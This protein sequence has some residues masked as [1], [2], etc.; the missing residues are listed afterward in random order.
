MD[1]NSKK[2]LV[3]AIF[4]LADW[5]EYYSN[6]NTSP[7][8]YLTIV[9]NCEP[10]K[11]QCE[12]LLLEMETQLEKPLQNEEE[13]NKWR[14]VAHEYFEKTIKHYRSSLKLQWSR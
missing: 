12:F 10:H 1:I 13:R 5:V 3:E 9:E 14:K 8:F 7:F 11:W 2:K 6:R 4:A